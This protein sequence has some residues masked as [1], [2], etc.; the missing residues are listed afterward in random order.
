MTLPATIV[1]LPLAGVGFM[2]LATVIYPVMLVLIGTVAALRVSGRPGARRGTFSAGETI[3]ASLIA[4][5]AVGFGIA[6]IISYFFDVTPEDRRHTITSITMLG[7]I[8]GVLGAAIFGIAGAVTS[9]VCRDTN[10]EPP[11]SDL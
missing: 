2:E 8:A 5:P 3:V 1:T 4:G 11:S 9:A 6:L 10:E 7:V